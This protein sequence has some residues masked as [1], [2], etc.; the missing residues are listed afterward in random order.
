MAFASANALTAPSSWS[1]TLAVE[2]LPCGTVK[3]TLI[4]STA[5]SV[6]GWQIEVGTPGAHFPVA[7]DLPGQTTAPTWPASG[8]A[9]V[10]DC[11]SIWPEPLTKFASTTLVPEPPALRRTPLLVS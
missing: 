1:C 5:G 3:L 8:I 2:G 6:V 11:T 4:G 10:P 9:S 7:K